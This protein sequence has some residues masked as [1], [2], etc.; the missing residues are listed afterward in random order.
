MMFKPRR[1]INAMS[2]IEPANLCLQGGDGV[3]A[4]LTGLF[5][6]IEWEYKGDRGWLGRLTADG[7]WYEFRVPAGEDECWTIATSHDND[8]PELISKICAA[9]RLLA[10][11]GQAL[12]LIDPGGRRP[13]Q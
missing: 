3:R 11:D 7:T 5:P 1:T 6:G 2:E 4:E 13:A 9:M 8:E 12:V 10:F